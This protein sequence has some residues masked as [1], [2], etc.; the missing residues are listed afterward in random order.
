MSEIGRGELKIL[1]TGGTGFIGSQL[2]SR[3]LAAGY[4]V[5]VLVRDY[6]SARLRLGAGPELVKSLDEIDEKQDFDV[7]INL[8]GAGIADQRW[9]RSRK[10]VLLT[11]RLQTTRNLVKLFRRMDQPPA[12]L[13]SA[14]A[15]GFYGSGSDEPLTENSLPS[16]EFT[17]ELC[18]RW[19]EEAQKAELL[20]VKVCIVRL[21]V[22]LGA[23]GGM[24]GRLLPIFRLGLGGRTGD[25]R[26][27]LSWVHKEDVIRCLF[28]LM[29]HHKAGIFNLTAPGA[30]ANLQFSR[31]LASELR[32]PALL[33]MPAAMVQLMFGEM[34]DRLLLNGQN[35]VP[36]RL[37]A[38]GFDFTY[39]TID[40]ALRACLCDLRPN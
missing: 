18:K 7:V 27:I 24:L 31:S 29:E 36:A 37:K 34:G 40:T 30:V 8:A 19:E 9:S 23:D 16:D 35:V 38:E 20:G 12:Q 25:G 39:P 1:V 3:C 11:S 26:Q 32:R 15:I 21:G 28:W 14:S 5:T 4:V 10:K 13:I 6:A 22:V 17:H 2:V 33:P